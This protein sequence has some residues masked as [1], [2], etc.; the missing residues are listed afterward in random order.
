MKLDA[1]IR[2]FEHVREIE[3]EEERGDGYCYRHR[4]WYW[5][6]DCPR[7]V[8]EFPYLLEEET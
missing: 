4:R 8:D 5:G 7:C 6:T 3:A 2:T 1:A